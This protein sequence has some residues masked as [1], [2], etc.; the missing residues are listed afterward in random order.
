MSETTPSGDALDMTPQEALDTLRKALPHLSAAVK[1]NPYVEASE[2]ERAFADLAAYIES[3]TE[4]IAVLAD[5]DAMAAIE[6]S[7]M[8]MD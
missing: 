7:E 6:D 4:T 2:I 3:A 5:P 1:V 8:E